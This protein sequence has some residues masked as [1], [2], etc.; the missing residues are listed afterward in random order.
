MAE[1]S[2]VGKNIPRKNDPLRATGAAKYT[3]DMY[4]PGMLHG[5]MLRSPYPHARILNIKTDKA[6]NLPGVKC[7]VTG[8][9]TLG[10]NYGF[11]SIPPLMDQY[12]IAVDKI[13]YVGDVVAAVAAIDEDTATE[14]LDLIDVEYEVLPA[15]FDPIEAMR[16]GAPQIHAHVEKN[17]S[18]EINR[19]FREVDRAF[20]EA[21]YVREDEFFTQAVEHCP[22][23]TNT[24]IAN[25]DITGKLTVWASHKQPFA[26]QK[27]L[28]R[29]L[30]LSSEPR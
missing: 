13:R 27:L 7:V 2:V 8:N 22:L 28:E 17:I 5:K 30:G 6:K 29:T 10:V 16:L 21:D 11:V 3:G 1:F 14:A 15:V 12:G 4:L 23:E 19:E 20:S 26:L 24:V 9:D 25:Y 18:V